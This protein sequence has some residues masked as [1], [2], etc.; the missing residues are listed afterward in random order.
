MHFLQWIGENWGIVC[1]WIGLL[2]NSAGLVYNLCKLLRTGGLRR[3]QD[4]IAVREAARRFECE[5]EELTHLGGAEKL[6]YVLCRLREYVAELG[7]HFTEEELTAA[8][9]AD[10]AFS[11]EV[12]ATKSELLE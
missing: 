9:E 2:V 5:A 8:V 12:N 1:V 10:I 3:A 7:A 11:K 6:Q 4:W